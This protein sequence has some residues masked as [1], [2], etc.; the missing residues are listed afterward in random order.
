MPCSGP[1]H[2]PFAASLSARFAS[3]S[4]LSPHTV[5]KARSR[6][7]S[8]SMRSRYAVTSSTGERRFS[9]MSAN[10]H[11]ALAKA[12]S[13]AL[14]VLTP[15][16]RDSWARAPRAPGRGHRERPAHRGMHSADGRSPWR[17]R[18]PT[19][20][21][22]RPR[23]A[24]RLR[25]P[26]HACASYSTKRTL[27]ATDL[28]DSDFANHL[29]ATVYRCCH[30]MGLRAAK[31]NRA[32]RSGLYRETESSRMLRSRTQLTPH[33][34]IRVLFTVHVDVELVGVIRKRSEEH[35]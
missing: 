9:R 26:G 32:R 25:V 7:S 6:P 18:H 15:R 34:A 3:T 14:P 23:A 35:T 27:A 13:S 5:M 16:P 1:R 17:P 29:R 22:A 20:W 33:L 10:C 2:W 28:R 21:T 4:A 31:T 24:E 8:R 30:S 12:S 19:I 11:D